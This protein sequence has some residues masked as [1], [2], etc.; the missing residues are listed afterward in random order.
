[1][2][3][4]DFLF[5]FLLLIVSSSQENLDLEEKAMMNIASKITV[6]VSRVRSEAIHQSKKTNLDPSLLHSKPRRPLGLNVIY[7]P[8]NGHKADIVFIHGLGGN[9]RWTWSKHRNPE[10][11]W[12]LTFL[13]L[14]P[15]L[16]L[17][18][19]LSFGYNANFRRA[20]NVSTAV[21]DFAKELLFDLKYAKD[22][23]KEDLRMGEAYMQG[24][25]DPEYEHII[26]SIS[27]I[28]FLATPHRG[29]NLADVLNRILQSTVVSN[30]KQYISELAKNSFT[31][32]KLNEQ[33]RHIAPR[34]DIVSFYETQPTSIGLMNAR[35]MVL[36]KDSSVLGYP[37]E[38]SKALNAD[39]HGVCKFDGPSDPN[40]I[41]VRNVLKTLVS[42]IISMNG[43]NKRPEI[44]RRVSS[45]LKATLAISELPDID[46][47]FF[48]DQWTPG[49][50]GWLLEDTSYV[51]WIKTPEPS[52]CIIWLNGGAATGK[53]VLSSFVINNLV[54]QGLRCQ[55][56]YIRY[57][58]R[59]KRTLSFLLRTIAYQIAQCVPDFLEKIFELADEGIDFESADP[60][61]IWERAFKS[62]LFKLKGQKPLYWVIDGLDEA[63]DSRASI[64][65]LS[66]IMPALIPIR[67][68]FVSRETSE[69]TAA[70]S[71]IP[72]SI[73]QRV[74][75][76]EAHLD[77]LRCHARHELSMPGSAEHRE[78]IVERVVEGAQN[79]FLELPAGMEAIYDRMAVS[80]VQDL[81]PTDQALASTILQ[82]VAC[83]FRDLTIAELSQALGQDISGMLD[84]HQSIVS[85]CG[86]FVVVDNSEKVGMIHQTAR[87]YL[88][89]KSH[90][91]ILRIDRDA[92]HEHL[93]LCCVGVLM[94][95]GLRAKINR[96]KKP[97]LLEYCATWWPSH[98]AMASPHSEKA[99]ETLNKLLTGNWILTWI[100]ALAASKKLRVLVQA[101]RHLLKYA[102]KRGDHIAKQNE[103][104]YLVE[105]QFIESWAMDFVKL[106]GKF[107]PNLRRNPESIYK[108]I[109]AFCPHNST[110]YRQ[111]GKS[112]SKSLRVSGLSTVDWDDLLARL[113]LG[114]NTYASSI[115]ANG[116]RIAI[117]ASSGSVFV[118]D[119]SAFEEASG[120]P[121]KHGE[122]V[123]RMAMNSTGTLVVTYGFKTT[124][125]WDPLTGTCHLT[126]Q[127]LESRPRPLALL[128]TNNNN[129]L[130]VG[131]DDRRIRS[132]SLNEPSPTW[133]LVAEL[134]EPELEGH[135]LNSSSY[136]ALNNDGSLAAVAYRGH[137]L[138]AWEIDGPVHIN[139]CWRARKELSRGEVIEAVWHPHAPEILGLYI[140]GTAFKWNPYRGEPEEISTGASKLA[141]SK[142]G[143][144]FVTGDVHGT[145]KIFAT[146]DFRLL[147]KLISQDPVLGLAFSPDLRRFYDIRGYYG[148]AW[149]PNVLTRYAASS[150]KQ[151]ERESETESL[152]HGCGP[153]MSSSQRIDAITVLEGSPT[154]RLYCYGTE[155]GAVRL[156]D[157]QQGI[158]TEIHKSKGFLSI[159]EL[160][161]SCDGRYVCF[162]D[163][164]KKVF[165]MTVTPD[166]AN[167]APV[168]LLRAEVSM[169]N[170]TK[171]PILQLLFSAD[172]T[173]LLVC[174]SSAICTISIESALITKS[175]EW[176]SKGCKCII[177]PQMPALVIQF[178]S[179]TVR[180]FNWDLTEV[181][182]FRVEYPNNKDVVS[183][184]KYDVNVN[185]V[186]R[187]IV[188][189]DRRHILAQMSLGESSKEKAFSFFA[190]SAF[191][192]HKAPK[193]EGK[194]ATDSVVV[195]PVLLPWQLVTQIG[196]ILFFHK[197]DCLIFLSKGFSI[198][199]W[200][201]PSH[202][203]QAS[204]APFKPY[205]EGST[206]VADRDVEPPKHHLDS[207]PSAA[208]VQTVK[209]IFSLPGDW[210]SR[211][212]LC[213]CSIWSAEKSLLCPRNGEVALVRSTGLA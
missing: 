200:Q 21:L 1:M 10:L 41:T 168:A 132:L 66:D 116:S 50:N 52:H 22:E 174:T 30:S 97:E 199:S 7:T 40:Y 101:S 152:V 153:I 55:Y 108:I 2:A 134:E 61:T 89:N 150:G 74:V 63:N 29:A 36:E 70:L 142:D 180:T 184:A 28:T 125:V 42:K 159:E 124:K 104:C 80:I 178:Q 32:Q 82:C 44:S 117:L 177:H 54:E 173:R 26:K 193:I 143:S 79:N 92:A 144:L 192:A 212:C 206:G 3:C 131:T 127:N 149:E 187:L 201:I 65:L 165:I 176:H 161:W 114:F 103:T 46:Y 172:A 83:S 51:E 106:V 167:S 140:E 207:C 197:Q 185:T 213:L 81:S 6:V 171:G 129:T 195:T 138:S 109:P 95:P 179:H 27:A 191:S 151:S 160:T 128:L 31:L 183:D 119:A 210:I 141:I 39:H 194:G 181:R 118:H 94:S 100:H 135:F 93:F 19:I 169:K 122:R 147:Y 175:L 115:F 113:S 205:L 190:V 64:R 69:I 20:G 110:V 170:C 8:K 146:S 24:Q 43:P 204:E 76:I 68:L 189:H 38:T 166:L 111:F 47:I 90:D 84:F 202:L 209:E 67:I 14:E 133:Q 198:C 145:V 23:R 164:S 157:T 59:R 154:G 17:A 99:V 87:E 58:D 60:R 156:F 25:N 139:H 98:L 203:R 188:T 62:Y 112:E 34:L 123:Y 15:D 57:G 148:N 5:M 163:S 9:S 73:P 18:R 88:L 186:D 211:E 33:F 35:L 86:G 107:G 37:G 196:L 12:P 126:V 56:F 11:L 208:A 77:D 105:Q 16:C 162:S 45:D 130:L 96:N 13:P 71:K 72:D 155:N 85:L 48:R 53:S 78:A 137:P 158:I 102:T 121:I 75:K 136:M 4:F 49:T 182:S 91:H 120:S